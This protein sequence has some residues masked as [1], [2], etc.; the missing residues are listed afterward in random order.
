MCSNAAL[1]GHIDTLKYLHE[2][3]C[4][5]NGTTWACAN[6]SDNQDCIEYVR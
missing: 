2:N 6:M 5:W 1:N 3:G 4:P